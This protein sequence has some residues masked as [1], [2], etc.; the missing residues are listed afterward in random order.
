MSVAAKH[1][2]LTGAKGDQEVQEVKA[3]AAEA[4]AQQQRAQGHQATSALQ[5]KP[6]AATVPAAI[7]A[8]WVRTCAVAKFQLWRLTR[9]APFHHWAACPPRVRQQRGNGAFLPKTEAPPLPVL[10][11]CIEFSTFQVT[12]PEQA[13]EYFQAFDAFLAEAERRR[14]RLALYM[15]FDTIPPAPK[16]R[17]MLQARRLFKLQQ[18]WNK[19]QAD[20]LTRLVA[21]TVAVH[22]NAVLRLL[23]NMVLKVSPPRNP[24]RNCATM[25]KAHTTMVAWITREQQA[26]LALEPDSD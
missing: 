15:R 18:P 4:Q 16:L 17:Q 2:P 6:A 19:R 9:E 8:G 20:R 13:R 1:V 7:H 25:D 22:N 26:L 11:G 24:Y 21:W 3:E 12:T 5:A 14:V 10:L 23:V